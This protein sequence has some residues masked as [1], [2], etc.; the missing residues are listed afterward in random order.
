MTE[1]AKNVGTS[2]L[3]RVWDFCVR[4]WQHSLKKAV[5]ILLLIVAGMTLLERTRPFGYLKGT[6][7][8]AF[9]RSDT[10]EMPHNL[11]IVEITGDD[12][13][14][15]FGGV[16]PL[17]PEVMFQLIAALG[18]LQPSV[19]GVDVDTS[20]APWA[21]VNP[22]E[23]KEGKLVN[24]KFI[25]AQV[26]LEN[27]GSDRADEDAARIT[28][29]PVVGGKI[30]DETQMGVARFPQDEDGYVRGFRSTYTVEGKLPGV[31]RCPASPANKKEQAG[32]QTPA[33]AESPNELGNSREMPAFFRAIAEAY[34]LS[35][36]KNQSDE[37]NKEF[38]QGDSEVKYLKF[39]GERRHFQMVDAGHILAK[40]AAG[41]I[42]TKPLDADNLKSL[43]S[44]MVLIGG[45][46]PEAR[47]EY[48]TPLGLMPGVELI[49]NAVENELGQSVREVGILKAIAF[50]LF[51]GVL[52]VFI[53]FMYS[54]RPVG[55]FILSLAA[56][57]LVVT[58]GAVSY[59]GVGAFLNFVPVMA[60]MVIHQMI[61]GTQQAAELKEQ[62]S[63]LRKDVTNKDTEIAHLRSELGD[64]RLDR[65]FKQQTSPVPPATLPIAPLIIVETTES[66]TV[67]EKEPEHSHVAGK[68]KKTHPHKRGHAAGK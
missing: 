15:L 18:P 1:E 41:K 61:E 35:A 42:V 8:D 24:A 12:Y 68:A 20:E 47:D 56:M 25:W 67:V 45:T 50:D 44:A 66:T 4:F 49:A 39:T 32:A 37:K 10:T 46:Y 9:T 3:G 57:G 54:N 27:H 2:W 16:S 21:C 26:P 53:Y 28:L 33:E 17:K 23:L 30:T 62:V 55:A 22:E 11:V 64:V 5:P 29:G 48:Y 14:E 40:N 36:S 63:K 43:Q 34:Y 38:A 31:L 52:I 58:L 59:Y 19:V 7:I 60:G 51:F 13:K 65:A 6:L